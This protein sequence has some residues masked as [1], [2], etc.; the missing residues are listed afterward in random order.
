MTDHETKS[1]GSDHV[2]PA[3]PATPAME[4]WYEQDHNKTFLIFLLLTLIMTIWPWILFGA[5]VRSDGIE[6]RGRAARVAN[7]HQQDVT[8]FV[9]SISNCI[10]L[11]TGYLFSKAVASVA[12]KWIVYK[13]MDVSRVSFFTALK[14][15]ATP[16][17]LFRQGRYR[18]FLI[19]VLYIAIFIFVTPGMTALLLPHPF[20]R[21]TSLYGKELDFASNNTDCISWF[22]NNTI[23]PTCD[24][25]VSLTTLLCGYCTL[26]ALPFC[27]KTY[28]GFNYTNCLAENQMVDVLESGRGSVRK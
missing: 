24:W 5:I 22:N 10:T 3:T 19:V 16:V 23:S 13:E 27:L 1:T 7:D 20:G 21:N 14:N 25:I 8:F 26:S 6:M 28:N 2:T 11:I 9:T 18:P 15:R 17:S 12:Q 4:S